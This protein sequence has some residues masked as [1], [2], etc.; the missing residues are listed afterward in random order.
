MSV[1][2]KQ[3]LEATGLKNSKTLTR[4]ANRGIIPK[5][6]VGTHPAGRGKIAYWPDWVLGRCQ[7]IADL[8]RQGHTVGSA[9]STLEYERM[10]SLIEE[11]EKT[12]DLKESLSKKKVMLAGGR[13]INLDLFLHAFIA[14]AADNIAVSEPVRKQLVE[15]MRNAGVAAWSLKLIANGYNPVCLF[16]GERVEV[17]ADFILSHRLAESVGASWLVIPTLPSLRKALSVLGRALPKDPV[18]W[19]APK[20]Q[21]RDGDTIVEYDVLLLENAL[22]FE[23]IRE[24]AKTI[25]MAPETE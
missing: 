25:G 7:R 18:V 8:T 4:W 5:P 24:T 3:I 10:L 20:I 9:Y 23:L 11:V 15:Q 1:T 6:H 2:S 13:E 16:D 14:N 12:P 17:V 19:P 22:G 21:V